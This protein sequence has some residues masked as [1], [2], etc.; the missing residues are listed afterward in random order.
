MGSN[1]RNY[2][3]FCIHKVTIVTL[4]QTAGLH[5]KKYSF[6]ELLGCPAY[7]SITSPNIKKW[8]LIP[9]LGR[10]ILALDK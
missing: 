8:L 9:A 7:S 6:K 10:L 1:C 3:F 5:G 2:G 4:C